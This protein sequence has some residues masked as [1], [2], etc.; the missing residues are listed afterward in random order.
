MVEVLPLDHLWD[1]QKDHHNNEKA[2]WCIGSR[3][4]CIA[5]FYK[6]YDCLATLGSPIGALVGLF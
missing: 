1:G 3:I 6:P 4:E 2:I 5:C